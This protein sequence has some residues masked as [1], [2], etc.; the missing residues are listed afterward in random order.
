MSKTISA[1]GGFTAAQ[2]KS[3][4]SIPAQSDMT[5]SGSDVICNRIK[6]KSIASILGISNPKGLH[7]ISISSAVNQYSQFSSRYWL[8]SGGT[9][10]SQPKTRSLFSYFAGYNHNA[11]TPYFTFITSDFNIYE[12]STSTTVIA[13]LLLGEVKW[14][15]IPFLASVNM[16]VKVNG[17]VVDTQHI[18]LNSSNYLTTSQSFSSFIN[19]SAWNTNK[20]ITLRFYFG[21]DASNSYQELCSVPTISDVSIAATMIYKAK[22]RSFRVSDALVSTLGGNAAVC[23]HYGD[24][25]NC[26]VTQS[27][28]SVTLSFHGIDTNN[29]GVGDLNLILADRYLW[30]K[31]NNDSFALLQYVQMHNDDSVGGT[32][33]CNMDTLTYGDLVDIEIR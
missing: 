23:F 9:L 11:Q 2:L 24:L 17:S 28:S 1:Y 30:Y 8:L 14:L 3:R 12:G 31:R 32:Y 18:T 6:L 29:D 33:G 7:S 21:K 10:I 19:T 26:Y 4:A 22:L 20:T 13:S 5:V 15:D 25:A 27:S 16:E